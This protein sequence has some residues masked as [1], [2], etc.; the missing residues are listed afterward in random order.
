[1]GKFNGPLPRRATA[2]V[3]D[4]VDICAATPA[5]RLMPKIVARYQR[6]GIEVQAGKAR[7]RSSWCRTIQA[8]AAAQLTSQ[9]A[10]LTQFC[11]VALTLPTIATVGDQLERVA[12]SGRGGGGHR[13]GY[14]AG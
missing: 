7:S 6:R 12:G 13:E 3:G 11:V 5:G 8:G 9:P 1:M 2:Y 14:R 10:D 4:A